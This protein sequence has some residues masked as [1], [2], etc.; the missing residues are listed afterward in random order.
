M[1]EQWVNDNEDMHYKFGFHDWI[2]QNKDNPDMLKRLLAFRYKF[3]LEEWTE[4]TKAYV[5]GDPEEFIDGL[6]DFCV[7]AVGTLDLMQVDGVQAWDE[8]HKAN[9]SKIRGVKANRPNPLGLP[10][11]TKPSGWRKPS[12]EGNYGLLPLAMEDDHVPGVGPV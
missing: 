4:I 3:L 5:D 10:D 12:H 7:V 11:L 2:E 6:I 8:V 9:M 1:S